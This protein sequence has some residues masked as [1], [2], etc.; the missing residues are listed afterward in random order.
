VSAARG[1]N[2]QRRL[3]AGNASV[4]NTGTLST[5]P[6]WVKLSRVGNVISGYESGDGVNWTLVASDTFTM[7]DN[8]LIGLGVSSH[9][10]GTKAAAQLDNAH[11]KSPGHPRAP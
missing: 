6:R 7:P 10:A 5:A 9:V 4:G 11:R 1:V 3:A 2:Y 8:A